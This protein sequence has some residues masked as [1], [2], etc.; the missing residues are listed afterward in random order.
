M[1]S[2]KGFSG[3]FDEREDD[4]ECC[5]VFDKKRRRIVSAKNVEGPCAYVAWIW[6]LLSFHAVKF[7]TK[8]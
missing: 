1:A 7:L 3:F 4:D 5:V 2:R 6:L 8:A